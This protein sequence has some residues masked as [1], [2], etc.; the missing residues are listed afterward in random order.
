MKKKAIVPRQKMGKKA[1]RALD[2]KKRVTWGFSPTS[3]VKES[4]RVYKREKI[5]PDD[6]RGGFFVP[7]YRHETAVWRV[8]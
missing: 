5:R 3:R 2:E 8:G 7:S 1:Q 4:R 6:H